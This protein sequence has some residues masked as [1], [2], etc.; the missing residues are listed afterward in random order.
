MDPQYYTED[1]IEEVLIQQDEDP[2][3]SSTF[4]KLLYL[5]SKKLSNIS[6]IKFISSGIHRKA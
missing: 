4:N 6:R 3:I 1:Y 2:I 5:L